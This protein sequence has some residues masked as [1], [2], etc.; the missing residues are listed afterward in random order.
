MK[1]KIVRSQKLMLH[2]IMKSTKNSNYIMEPPFFY[3][4]YGVTLITYLHMKWIFIQ[5]LCHLAS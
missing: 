3:E 4:N 5:L 1:C 2:N